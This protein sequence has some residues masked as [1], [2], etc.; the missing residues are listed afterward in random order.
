MA[1]FQVEVG[2]LIT[3]QEGDAYVIEAET[4]E[5]AVSKAKSLL[6]E[7]ID[8]KHCWCDYDDSDISLDYL[9]ECD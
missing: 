9:I 5:E 6:K 4:A 2:A 7:K 8:N 3:I 1:K